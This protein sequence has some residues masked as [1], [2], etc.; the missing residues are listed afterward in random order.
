MTEQL[1][2]LLVHLGKCRVLFTN[3]RRHTKPNDL[4]TMG[5]PHLRGM[6]DPVAVPTANVEG[7]MDR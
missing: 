1:Y 5:S 3:A 2:V 4:G 7:M 6:R